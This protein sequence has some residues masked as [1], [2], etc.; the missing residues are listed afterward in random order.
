MQL[1][2]EVVM[3]EVWPLH[4]CCFENS[5]IH[6][7]SP[8]SWYV[9]TFIR[10]TVDEYFVRFQHLDFSNKICLLCMLVSHVGTK[11]C[12]CKDTGRVHHDVYMST[13]RPTHVTRNTVSHTHRRKIYPTWAVGDPSQLSTPDR[14]YHLPG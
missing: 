3:K 2:F 14:S 12:S 13:R 5:R 4:I 9:D 11:T 10:D 6:T 1:A 7:L 8:W